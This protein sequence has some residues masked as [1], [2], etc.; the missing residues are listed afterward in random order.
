MIAKLKE[1]GILAVFHY[2]PLHSSE[3]FRTKHDG[4]ELPNCDRW[5]DTLVRLPLYHE[6]R[7]DDILRICHLIAKASE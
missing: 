5:A 3:F 1:N 7:D 4:R 2:L 6:L